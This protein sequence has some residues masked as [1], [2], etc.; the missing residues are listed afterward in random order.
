M[1]REQ[2]ELQHRKNVL[3]NIITCNTS[4]YHIADSYGCLYFIQYNFF[5]PSNII[6]FRTSFCIIQPK[7]LVYTRKAST[8]DSHRVLFC[9][10]T[11]SV[12]IGPALVVYSGNYGKSMMFLFDLINGNLYLPIRSILVQKKQKVP[13]RS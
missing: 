7:N 4:C 6:T 10:F 8:S 12:S 2:N 11:F 1:K 9:C 5:F 3:R 13:P